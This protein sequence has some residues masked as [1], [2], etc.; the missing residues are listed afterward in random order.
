MSI[1]IT[2]L[3][4]LLNGQNGQAQNLLI[5]GTENLR[6]SLQPNMLVTGTVQ[7]NLGDGK[8]NVKFMKESAV[9]ESKTPLT[10]NELIHGRVVGVGDKIEL[11]RVFKDK[12]VSDNQAAKQANWEHLS[13]A[14]SQGARAVEV[15]Q[16]YR[17]SL[18]ADEQLT[19]ASMLKSGVDADALTLSAVVL[20]KMGV[21]VTSTMLN[22]LYPVLSKTLNEKF[23]LQNM[24][25]YLDFEAPQSNQS[26]AKNITELAAFIA[27]ATGRLPEASLQENKQQFLE[28]FDPNN[29]ESVD[30]DMDSGEQQSDQ[31]NLLFDAKRILLNSQS[32]GTVSHRVTV[33]PFVINDKLV[34]VDMALFSQREQ[35]QQDSIKHRKI[36]L[37]L[38][39][40]MLGQ[41]DIEINMADKHARININTENNLTTNELVQFMPQLKRDFSEFSIQLDELNYGTIEKN[42]LGNVIGSVVEH[43][44]SQDSLSRVY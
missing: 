13:S 28:Q 26:N 16:G 29:T 21:T 37:S 32:D 42:K 15:L 20:N 35:Q 25:A 36:A 27:D 34:E 43:Y 19:L 39:T 30:L 6:N 4:G 24:T 3:L 2:G 8:Y 40:D 38:D 12:A 44:I 23:Q 5:S 7:A 41:V 22:T 17:V 31:Q 1:T 14:G 11:Q 18:S 9:V 33:V 10:V